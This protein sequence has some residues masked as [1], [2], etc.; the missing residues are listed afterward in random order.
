MLF[1]IILFLS[2]G[3]FAK[4][5]KKKRKEGRQA[6][7]KGKKKKENN[8]HHRERN[9]KWVWEGA[10]GGGEGGEE[11]EAVTASKM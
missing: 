3:C 2:H 10:R 7:R 5:K 1:K 9:P 4:G 11:R 8:K 6:G